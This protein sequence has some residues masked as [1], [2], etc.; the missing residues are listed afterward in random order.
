[1]SNYGFS[2]SSIGRDQDSANAL[3]LCRADLTADQCSDCVG[4]AADQLLAKCPSGTQGD[5]S[6]DYCMMR[7]SNE[8]IIGPQTTFSSTTTIS[9]NN[10]SDENRF[11]REDLSILLLNLRVQAANGSSELKVGAGARPTE[12]V[13]APMIYGLVQCTPY[14]S[15][16]ECRRCLADIYNKVIVEID[17]SREAKMIMP[18]C[19]RNGDN[20]FP[21]D[22]PR[23]KKRYAT[24]KVVMISVPIC[25]CVALAVCAVIYLRKRMTRRPR[26]R[27]IIE[28][29]QEINTVESL[30]YDLG[31]IRDATADF[32]DSN[33]LGQGGFGA[34]YRGKLQDGQEIAVKRLSKNSG[35]GNTEFKNEV[36]LVARLQHRNLVRLLGFSLEGTE[37]LLVYEFVQNA[38][39][40]QFIFDPI[41]RSRLDWDIRHK[42]IGGVARGLVYLHEDSRLRIIH[43][44]LKAGNVL[45][46]SDMNPKIAD[47]GMAR[48]SRH[49]EI[50][51]NTSRIVGTYGYMAPEYAMHGQF[52]IKSDVFSFGVLM[53]EIVS[54]QRNTCISRGDNVENLLTLTWE[55]WRRGTV[56]EIIDP[57]LQQNSRS[58]FSEMLK[59]IHIGLLCVE[60]NGANRPTMTSVLHMLNASSTST[61]PQPLRPAFYMGGQFGP[62]AALIIQENEYC[63][64]R[65]EMIVTELYP[66]VPYFGINLKMNSWHLP[67]VYCQ[68]Y[69]KLEPLDG[70]NY[71]RWSQKLLI[72][73]EQL[74]V[75]YVLFSDPSEESDPIIIALDNDDVSAAKEKS[76]VAAA[77]A[78]NQVWESLEKK[79]GGDNARKRKYVVEKWL[80][81]CML[82]DKPVMEQLHDHMRTEEAN[83]LKDKS[84]SLSSN[85][86]NANLVESNAGKGKGRFVLKKDK[87]DWKNKKLSADK[88]TTKKPPS[89]LTCWICRNPGHKAYQFPKRQ[90]QS[91][92]PN[93]PPNQ[94]HLTETDDIVAAFIVEANLVENKKD[95]VLDIGPS[96]HFCSN[97]ELFHDFE[98]TGEGKCIY[99]ENSSV[100]RV[101]GKGQIL[102]KLTSGKTLSLSNALYIPSMRRNPVSGALL[103]KTGL[104]IVLEANRAVLTK[105]GE[106]HVFP[107]KSRDDMNASGSSANDHVDMPSSSVNVSDDHVELRR[108]KRQR[109]ETSFGPDFVTAF[110]VK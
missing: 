25:V 64:T 24:K 17:K 70:A 27:E 18:D 100:A 29:I 73:F 28:T 67:R 87:P 109:I 40:D 12:E 22:N 8:P 53:L 101:L 33:K 104:K 82:D 71:K 74:E 47:F 49:D 91:Q 56:E 19:R 31:D 6:G 11:F 23:G 32:D 85:S 45:L 41:K 52:S 60:E 69:R 30:Q 61:F 94:A 105:N 95:W 108:S 65:N 76:D 84:L 72:F 1:M 102:L 63:S 36:L 4:A 54:G 46:D 37:R 86:V 3:A 81:F 14:L 99:M 7:Y 20:G 39:L 107:F 98:D 13:K 59:C 58:S 15:S 78:T 79:Y 21:T 57:L 88:K 10:A 2:S 26:S 93:L 43:R 34:V 80:Q 77:A 44:D 42:I 92:R 16:E 66:R 38:S 103:N 90:G 97:K 106:F 89:K 83:W 51:G 5:V 96:R 48:L 35:Q 68:T 62:E 50:Q 110:L 9:V 75:D 55:N